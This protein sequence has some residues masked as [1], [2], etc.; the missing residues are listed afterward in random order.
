V[1]GWEIPKN[2]DENLTRRYGLIIEYLAEAFHY[3]SRNTNRFA[4]AKSV[5]KL[6]KGYD[7]RDQTAVLKTVCAFLKM[8]HPGLEPNQEEVEE[9][10]Q[11]AV[12]GRRRV[13]E[14]LNKRKKD[15]EFA[16]IDLSFIKSSGEVV[17]VYCPESRHSE[18]TQAPNRGATTDQPPAGSIPPPAVVPTPVQAVTPEPELPKAKERHYRIH[19]GATG[20]SYETIFKDY[21]PGAEEITVEDPYIRAHHQILGTHEE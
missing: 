1:P 4:Y 12:E 19:Y 16:A 8:L 2:R 13:K 6:G 9:Y 21:L 11:Y 5:C 3:L 10:L 7:Q 18:A 17:I 14:Q 20:F 15:D